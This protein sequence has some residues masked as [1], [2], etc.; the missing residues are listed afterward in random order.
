MA[1]HCRFGTISFEIF[2]VYAPQRGKGQTEI[3]LWWDHFEQVLQQRDKEAA[4]FILGDFNCSVGSVTTPG[5]G[6]VAADLED[7]GGTRL[8]EMCGRYSLCAPS[9]F[10][11]WH[12]GPS[13]T[14]TGAQGSLSRIDYILVPESS[15]PGIV[16]S[17]VHS[18]IDLMNGDHDHLPL[19]VECEV[20]KGPK[21]VVGQF[22]KNVLYNR[23]QARAQGHHHILQQMMIQAPEQPWDR[24]VNDH[25]NGL[26]N[27]LQQGAMKCCPKQKRQCRQLYFSEEAWKLC[28]RKDMRQQYRALQRGKAWTF[29]KSLFSCW[30]QGQGHRQADSHDRLC[31]HVLR[32][33]EALLYEQ[34]T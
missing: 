27:H 28:D 8:R 24:D 31:L 14:F 18:D 12:E 6:D 17:F 16:R 29:L 1:V 21:H 34:E 2:V 7:A 25:W 11:C 33:Q 15:V 13:H 3:E 23:S 9:T 26:R 30:K 22:R 19:V 20:S 32:C 5:I 4:L 10:S